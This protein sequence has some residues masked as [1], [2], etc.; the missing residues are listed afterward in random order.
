MG[1][2][3]KKTLKWIPNELLERAR[4]LSESKGF[5][6]NEVIRRALALGLEVL[7]REGDI[8]R[9]IEELKRRI[10]RLEQGGV[11]VREERPIK[12]DP[13]IEKLVEDI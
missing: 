13:F 11:V 8:L 4:R 7:E 12:R 6:E 2:K 1:V 5:N 10:E 9:E 3:R